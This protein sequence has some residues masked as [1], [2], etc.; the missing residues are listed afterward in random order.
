MR[1]HGEPREVM[2]TAYYDILLH[3]SIR[4][5]VSAG[6]VSIFRSALVIFFVYVEALDAN[7][8]IDYTYDRQLNSGHSAFPAP[9]PKT[10]SFLAS[11]SHT[12]SPSLIRR[13]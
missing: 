3:T 13:K 9:L 6:E 7:G 5:V 1:R 2:V 12:T 11:L 8:T 4:Q 10:S